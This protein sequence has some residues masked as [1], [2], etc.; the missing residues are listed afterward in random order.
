MIIIMIIS[1]LDG[2]LLASECICQAPDPL[3][4]SKKASGWKS[5][6]ADRLTGEHI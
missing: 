5:G 4:D 2:K 3:D 1:R 6:Q